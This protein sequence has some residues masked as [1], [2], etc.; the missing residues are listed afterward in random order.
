MLKKNYF[1]IILLTL[2]FSLLAACNEKKVNIDEAKEIN[3]TC[4]IPK[5]PYGAPIVKV[6]F[7]IS[8]NGFIKNKHISHTSGYKHIDDLV[9]E[10]IETCKYNPKTSNGIPLESW[11]ERT[12]TWS[13]NLTNQ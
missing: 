3:G 12:Y 2:L 6:K 8:E 5:I 10:Y 7:T 4:V 13:S 9:L 11:V 1:Q